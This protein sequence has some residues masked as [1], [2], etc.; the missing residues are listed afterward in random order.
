MLE[1]Q[2]R[3]SSDTYEYILL[4]KLFDNL[5]CK[6]AEQWTGICWVP[7]YIGDVNQMLS[8]PI[9]SGF[10]QKSPDNIVSHAKQ[11]G[12]LN[13]W[14]FTAVDGTP[15]NDWPQNRSLTNHCLILFP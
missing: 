6:V 7:P 5:S 3:T 9:I 11:E 10:L 12:R 13:V 15:K 2:R 1:D 4:V 8:Q 14:V